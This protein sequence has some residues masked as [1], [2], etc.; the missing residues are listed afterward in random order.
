MGKIFFAAAL[1]SL[2]LL[3]ESHAQQI[4]NQSIERELPRDRVVSHDSRADAVAWTAGASRYLQPLVEWA[5]T[6]SAD[7]VTFSGRFK[8]PFGWIDRQQFLHIGRASGAYSIAINGTEV[9]RTQTGGV[10]G[11]FD[12]TNIAQEGANNLEIRLFKRYDAQIL[13]G[14]RTPMPAKISE[15]YILSQPRV[16]VRDVTIDTRMEGTNGLL[17]LGVILKSHQLNRHNYLVHWELLNPTGEIMAE[18]RK[19]AQIDMRREDTVRFFANIPRVVPWSPERPQLYTLYIRT[20][21]EGRFREHV[22]FR[23]GFR[24]IEMAADDRS[25]I[26]N[27]VPWGGV[28]VVDSPTWEELRRADSLGVLIAPRAD[29][30]THLSGLSRRVGGNPSNDPRWTSAYLERVL[31]TYHTAKNHASAAAFVIAKRSANGINLYESYLAVKQLEAS[32][33]VIYLDSEGEW[34]TDRRGSITDPASDFSADAAELSGGVAF[35]P[36]DAAAGRFSLR[37]VLKFTPFLGQAVYRIEQARKTVA[38][39]FVPLEVMPG[40]TRE[41]AV[42]LS[43]V[44]VDKN[45]TIFIEITA[46]RASGSYLPA[47]DANLKLYRRLDQPLPAASRTV[48]IAREFKIPAKR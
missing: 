39:G 13:E 28:Q 6:E 16:R 38:E 1:V 12:I 5:R 32:R 45:F 8:I 9:A 21:N 23:I 27:G 2:C 34:N 48:L 33:P 30:D 3:G 18:G 47:G 25:L 17:Q 15:V 46:E 43:G 41:F 42:P 22:A 24:T 31:G 37:N 19:D 4:D 26:L 20:Q 11:E 10:S 36:I 7:A 40:D 35:D 29:I 44:I 14:G